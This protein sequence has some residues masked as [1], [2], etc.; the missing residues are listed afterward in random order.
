MIMRD[1]SF[2][3]AKSERL[4]TTK[5]TLLIRITGKSRIFFGGQRLFPNAP[6]WQR[7]DDGVSQEYQRPSFSETALIGQ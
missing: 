6:S 3:P 4:T 5:I 2:Y 7:P 1:R